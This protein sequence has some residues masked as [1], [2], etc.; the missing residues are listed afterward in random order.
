M[1]ERERKGGRKSV[2]DRKGVSNV[3]WFVRIR[4]I[5]REYMCVFVYTHVCGYFRITVF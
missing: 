3:N 5:D 1:H 2:C 4:E